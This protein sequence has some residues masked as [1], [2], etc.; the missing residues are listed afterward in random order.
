MVKIAV[1]GSSGNV[2]S[3]LIE[4]RIM[5]LRVMVACDDDGCV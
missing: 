1:L 3:A 4:V 2:G 5:R